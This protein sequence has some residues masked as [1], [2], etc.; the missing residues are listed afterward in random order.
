MH[1]QTYMCLLLSLRRISVLLLRFAFSSWRRLAH[2]CV[3]EFFAQG[4]MEKEKGIPV[5]ML[6]DRDKVNCQIPQ[7]VFTL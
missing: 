3:D 4:D 2:L 7:T 5:Q 1:C 6:N